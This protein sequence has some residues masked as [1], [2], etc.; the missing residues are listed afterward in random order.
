M[1]GEST[2]SESFP[3]NNNKRSRSLL[4][5][6]RASFVGRNHIDTAG[7]SSSVLL[8]RQKHRSF[9]NIDIPKRRTK[10]SSRS[11]TPN[12]FSHHLSLLNQVKSHFIGNRKY[13]RTAPSVWLDDDDYHSIPSAI[14]NTVSN[15]SYIY[16]TLNQLHRKMPFT[17]ISIQ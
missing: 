12:S 16:S 4:R 11:K 1:S 2:D 7:E 10:K 9:D 17:K 8:L 3:S 13:R 6:V 5:Q 14:S 15:L